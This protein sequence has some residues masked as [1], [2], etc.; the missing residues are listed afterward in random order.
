MIEVQELTKR[1]G[2]TTAV[3]A[4]S[5]HV[6]RGEIVGFLGPNGAGKSTTLRMITGYLSPTSGRV[7]VGGIDV[8]DKPREARRL[9]GY[10]PEG[11]PMYRDMRVVEYLRFRAELKELGRR[12]VP[13]AVE[14]SLA[15]A[16]VTDAADKVIGRLSKGYRQRV[17]LAD[18]LLTDPPL[19]ILDEPSSG[20]DPNQNRHVRELLR[21]FEGNKTVLLSTHIL[22]QV[23]STCGRVIIIRKGQLMAQGKASELRQNPAGT[24]I[25]TLGG[26]ATPEAYEQ[27]LLGVTGVRNVERMGAQ[28]GGNAVRVTAVPGDEVLEAVFQAV[29]RAGLSLHRLVPESASLESVFADLTTTDPAA[30]LDDEPA[31]HADDAPNAGDAIDNEE[32]PS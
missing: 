24:R 11:V 25:I 6:P 1:Y 20:L 13:G 4:V 3:D 21:G 16:D 8:H 22:P 5:F 17:G 23:E 12:E 9:I 27:A 26:P 10:M 14:R 30:P 29:V 28:A 15:Q 2:S 19:L 32:S 18:A 7:R 31:A